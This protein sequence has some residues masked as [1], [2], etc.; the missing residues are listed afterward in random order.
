MSNKKETSNF[1]II[2]GESKI[3]YSIVSLLLSLGLNVWT[4]SRRTN[5]L[6]QNEFYFDLSQDPEQW[7]FP[8]IKFDVVFICASITSI[9]F[10]EKNVE[11]TRKINVYNTIKL[12][13][14]FIE[15][16]SFVV[17][18][19]S[20]LVFNG[21]SE[22]PSIHDIKQPVTEYGKQKDKV[23]CDLLKLENNIAIVR[24]TK[25][26]DQDFK[27]FKEWTTALYNN[28]NIFPFNDMVFSPI[29]IEYLTNFLKFLVIEKKNGIYHLSGASDISYSNSAFYIAKKLNLNSGLIVPISYKES[30]LTYVP[31]NTK[32]AVNKIMNF[33]I[34]APNSYDALDFYLKSNDFPS[35]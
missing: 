13:K 4:S 25:V 19:S 27:I 15:S 31:K 29:S 9:D 35:I 18:F 17:Y 26:I 32:L 22:S 10:C 8:G 33:N 16:E 1:L 12:V 2:G 23:E 24:L 30:A 3:G 5:V 21:E 34:D 14:F 7:E 20:N 11:E 28:R 6:H